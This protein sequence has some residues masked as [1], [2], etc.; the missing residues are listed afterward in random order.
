MDIKFFIFTGILSAIMYSIIY[1]LSY[2]MNKKNCPKEDILNVSF[3]LFLITIVMVFIIDGNDSNICLY[4]FVN[5]VLGTI[6]AKIAY[7]KG[8]NFIKWWIYGYFIF[9]IAIIHSILLKV[10]EDDLLKNN[11][12][13]YKK[14]PY[15]AEIIKK[16][17]II[18]RFCG[19]KL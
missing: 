3:I 18:C 12:N 7:K 9:F 1:F 11:S 13:F 16:E 15:C 17:A 8:R 14:C 10:K 4:F 2:Y 5:I 6:P 19:K